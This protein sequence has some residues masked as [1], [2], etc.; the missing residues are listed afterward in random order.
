MYEVIIALKHVSAYVAKVGNFLVD[1][2]YDERP[3][4]RGRPLSIEEFNEVNPQALMEVR[5][6]KLEAE[7]IIREA[8][9]TVEEPA[10]V[11]PEPAPELSEGEPEP[12]QDEAEFS[13]TDP[14]EPEPEL[15]G[16]SPI[17]ALPDGEV[18]AEPEAAP[19]PEPET[20]PEPQ[21]E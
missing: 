14:P 6:L 8:S 18:T 21:P 16:D 4:Y 13:E 1:S 17:E 20:E 9:E 12:D 10:P 2:R 19:E 11:E 15:A 5:T 3:I 7:I